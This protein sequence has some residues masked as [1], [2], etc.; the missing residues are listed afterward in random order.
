L[1]KHVRTD[2]NP[3]DIGSRGCDFDELAT[4]KL[5]WHGP[6][7][8]LLDEDKWPVEAVNSV[9]IDI[10]DCT[11]YATKDTV[12]LVPN[13]LDDYMDYPIGPSRLM[14]KD[15]VNGKNMLDQF[16]LFYSLQSIIGVSVKHLLLKN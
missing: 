10:D 15:S 11:V 13:R 12:H 5:W 2:A 7:F 3:A 6:Q 9:E 4:K 8:L 1:I 16:L 14:L